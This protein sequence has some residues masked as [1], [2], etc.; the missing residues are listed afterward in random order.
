MT[1]ALVLQF[2][3]SNFKTRIQ[4]KIKP[5][6]QAIKSAGCLVR[7]LWSRPL[8][9]SQGGGGALP[10]LQL[11]LL[12]TTKIPRKWGARKTQKGGSQ[13][14]SNQVMMY[15]FRHDLNIKKKHFAG[16]LGLHMFSICE[17]TQRNMRQQWLTS[18]SVQ[19]AP[20]KRRRWSRR[21]EKNYEKMVA[22]CVLNDLNILFSDDQIVQQ[23]C[24]A[25]P[26]IPP[27]HRELWHLELDHDLKAWWAASMQRLCIG[28]W[29]H[30]EHFK[31]LK[32]KYMFSN[33]YW[34]KVYWR[35]EVS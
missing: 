12:P 18:W 6:V 2:F 10:L 20:L 35:E 5:I 21:W 14:F 34:L 28:F 32:T 8:P 15:I 11:R 24:K 29:W 3:R 7:P 1:L 17:S 16:L 22:L 26:S 27:T 30:I 33:Q 25:K 13:I 31:T 4:L 23:R 19:W 9:A